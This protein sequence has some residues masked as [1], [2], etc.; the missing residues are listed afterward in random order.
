MSASSGVSLGRI[1]NT[2]TIGSS[3]GGQP[4]AATVERRELV[5]AMFRSTCSGDP[6]ARN[7]PTTHHAIGDTRRLT[8][9][10]AHV[11][12][13]GRRSLRLRHLDRA[14]S[15]KLR[16]GDIDGREGLRNSGHVPVAR[17]R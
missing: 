13:L 15:A 16:R 5:L 1:E 2:S 4:W 14:G 6:R 9:W 10:L 8:S 11:N 17:G 7:R 3:S 12:H